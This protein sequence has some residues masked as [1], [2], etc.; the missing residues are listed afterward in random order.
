MLL[1]VAVDEPV[2]VGVGVG[3]GEALP[4]REVLPVFEGEAPAVKE[5]VGEALCVLLADNVEVG[6]TA[7][8]PLAVPVEDAVG[9][10]VGVGAP[11]ALPLRE[12]LPVLLALAPAVKDAVGEDE[13]V[14]LALRVV[15]GVANG[16][17]EPVAVGEPVEVGVG[18]SGGV[19]LLDKELLPVLLA[20]AP[21][22]K[23]AVGEDEIVELA[24]SVVLGV[25]G[26]VAEPVAVGE[27]VALALLP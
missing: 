1:P 17:T 13:T 8:V 16:V 20:L 21:A 26:G 5:A 4:L 9:V 18:V 3:A 24:L 27:P 10:G 25:G 15:L 11:E 6:V 2:G 7:A 22:D 12:V 14:E 19:T 23:D